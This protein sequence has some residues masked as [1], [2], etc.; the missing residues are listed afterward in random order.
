DRQQPRRQLAA[1]E[2]DGG[3]AL[4]RQRARRGDEDDRGRR[5]HRASPSRQATLAPTI[6]T[7]AGTAG[8]SASAIAAPISATTTLSRP[9]IWP[10]SRA[11]NSAGNA[12]SR[13]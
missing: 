10:A 8:I 13:P 6:G 2:G 7:P 1:T 4:E 11:R 9:R 5:A 12:A 3:G